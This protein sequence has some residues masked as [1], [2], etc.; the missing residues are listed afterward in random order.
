MENNNT[1]AE[2]I[3]KMAKTILLVD[4]PSVDVPRTLLK[5][6][7]RIYSYSPGQYSEAVL[8]GDNNNVTFNDIESTPGEVD[9]V[10]IFRPEQEHAEI[11]E[12]HALPLKA[13]VIWLHP[14]VVST[15]TGELSKEHGLAFI[16]GVDIA[17]IAMQLKSDKL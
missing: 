1:F 12:M 10:N 8:G 4:W 3:L 11:I 16:E 7:F 17:E 9:I 14:P 15:K 13:N 5:A 2:H 6:G